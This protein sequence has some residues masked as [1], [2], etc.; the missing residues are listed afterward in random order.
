[1]AYLVHSLPVVWPS[2]AKCW[3]MKKIMENKES[4]HSSDEDTNPENA[5]KEPKNGKQD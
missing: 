5:R 1:M 2:G 3:K 4:R